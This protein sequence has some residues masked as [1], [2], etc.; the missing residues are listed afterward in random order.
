MAT[1]GSG[2]T[3]HRLSLQDW[4]ELEKTV[5]YLECTQEGKD[6][7]VGTEHVY[8]MLKDADGVEGIMKLPQQLDRD[9]F[10][11]ILHPRD[12]AE[13]LSL[14]LNQLAGTIAMVLVDGKEEVHVKRIV[15]TLGEVIEST[16]MV[17]KVFKQY[18]EECLISGKARDTSIV[19]HVNTNYI[20]SSTPHKGES[21]TSP[22]VSPALL[23]LAK[24]LKGHTDVD[25]LNM[26]HTLQLE[27]VRRGVPVG[28]PAVG[29]SI[30][31]NPKVNETINAEELGH[32]IA[33]SNQKFLD[34][35]SQK[36]FLRSK[37]PKLHTF[38]GDG[39][40]K[41]ISF[42]LWQSK[43]EQVRTG[44]LYPESAIIEAIFESLKGRAAESLRYISPKA[45][46]SEV[47]SVLNSKFGTA[48]SYDTLM[49]S[50]Y[51]LCQEETE[52]VSAYANR[53]ENKLRVIVHKYPENFLGN[54][55]QKTLRDRFFKG[56]KPLYSASLRHRYDNPE[57]PYQDLLDAAR[58]VEDEGNVYEK[59]VKK[60]KE[61]KEKAK[62]QSVITKG[63]SKGDSGGLADLAKVVKLVQDQMEVTQKAL[64][65]IT[66]S[67]KDFENR[68]NSYHVPYNQRGGG[69][70]N[71]FQ[72]RGRGRGYQ[73]NN[74]QGRGRGY[75]NGPENNQNPGNNPRNNPGNQPE[76]NNQNQRGGNRGGHRDG[77]RN[78]NQNNGNQNQNQN[79]NNAGQRNNNQG[80]PGNNQGRRGPYC[81]FCATQ[82][83]QEVDHW[84]Q[85]C[86]FVS[87]VLE[88]YHNNQREEGHQN[89]THN[90]NG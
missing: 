2:A 75:Y 80:N 87:S 45:S 33:E 8:Y 42:D 73:N 56:L 11:I 79:Q 71:N 77:Q 49:G 24:G 40:S 69:N 17:A 31:M 43:V 86:A 15:K 58:N 32:T 14:R 68:N 65:D 41:D 55:E 48:A 85:N 62:A 12:S 53:I 10:L 1:G 59:L 88:E 9:E 60:G 74:Y 35:L 63:D 84:P 83:A 34:N 82:G 22:I 23:E 61:N 66:E 78:G 51:T 29:G 13:M 54:T 6:I 52:E 21:P 4:E 44:G 26:F 72:G 89:N 67:F 46:L 19:W 28:E 64:K 7:G 90:L 81:R 39:S 57:I 47:L 3:R 30:G 20:I 50:F 36:G 27:C 37:I 5:F 38:S 70:Q 16:P 25:L 76:N 18:V